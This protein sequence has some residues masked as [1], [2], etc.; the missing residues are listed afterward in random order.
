[1]DVLYFGLPIKECLQETLNVICYVIIGEV[2]KGEEEQFITLTSLVGS[3]LI[4]CFLF[5]LV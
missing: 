5:V 2:L 3:E 1:M 4:L